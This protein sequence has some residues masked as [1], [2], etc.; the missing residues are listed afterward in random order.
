MELDTAKLH[1]AYQRKENGNDKEMKANVWFE[2]PMIQWHIRTL[3]GLAESM[4]I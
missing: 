2:C 1:S 3:S 4:I